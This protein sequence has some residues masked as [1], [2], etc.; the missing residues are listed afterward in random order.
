MAPEWWGSQGKAPAGLH[1]S[2]SIRIAKDGKASAGCHSIVR[3]GRATVRTAKAASQTKWRSKMAKPAAKKET[4]V[5]G[6]AVKEEQVSVIDTGRGFSI[7]TLPEERLHETSVLIVSDA[8]LV[9]GKFS[10][11]A[12]RMMRNKQ[13][14]VAEQARTAK[15]PEEEAKGALHTFGDGSGYGLPAGAFK[16]ALV[17]SV[18]FVGKSKSMNMTFMKGAI[19][20]MAD[21]EEED[22]TPLVRI[23]TEGYTIKEAFVRN[24]NGVAD[25]RYRPAFA[26]WSAL[27]N[28]AHAP[29]ISRAQIVQLV[30]A[31]GR[32][33]GIGEW[34]P[35]SKESKSGTWGTWRLA[36]AEEIQEFTKVRSNLKKAA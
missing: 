11:K 12:R 22:N 24:D 16:A 36:T 23:M 10:E 4:E 1:S 2:A 5:K 6:V 18:R 25:I 21:G 8:I 19:R 20:V 26:S 33:N 7:V 35:M 34:R 31:A 15:V 27:L 9:M 13:T 3:D 17:E 30:R 14:G 29:Q 28:I 32:F